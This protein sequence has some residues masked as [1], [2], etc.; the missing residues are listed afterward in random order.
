[1]A[2][3][4]RDA[5]FQILAA[6][7][8]SEGILHLLLGHH[9]ADQVE[10]VLIR[11]LGGSGPTGMAGMAP[12]VETAGLRILRPLLGVPPVPLRAMLVSADVAWVEDPSNAD[13]SALRPRLRL[14]RRDRDG[15][16][17]DFCAGGG[18][19]GGRPP[20]RAQ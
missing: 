16:R 20:A 19:G 15:R 18:G 3:R 17:R 4:A 1:M 9:A 8:A 2:E 11:T 14:L 10:T 13:P 6:A 12:L 7:C 5:R